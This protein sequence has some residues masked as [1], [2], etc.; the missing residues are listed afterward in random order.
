MPTSDDLEFK[1]IVLERKL[2]APEKLE[3][4]LQ[5]LENY[6]K[7]GIPK[8]LSGVLLD[9]EL[10]S[11]DQVSGI[12]K[13][14]NKGDRH[15]VR[16]YTILETLG[17]GGLGVVYKARRDNTGMFVALKIMYPNFAS[18]KEFVRRFMKEAKFSCQLN[19]VNVVKGIDFGD[20]NDVFYFAMEYVEGFTLKQYIKNLGRI[21]EPEAVKI[22]L[23]A[24]NGLKHIENQNL[25]H[26]DIKPDN[27]MLTQED[28]TVKLC[29]LGLA[30]CMEDA[31][32]LTAPGV[33]MGTPHYMSPEQGIAGGVI[34]I[35]SDIYSLGITL[36]HM[37]SGEV[38]YQGNTAVSILNQHVS[39]DL[40]SPKDINADLSES[41][42]SIISKMMAKKQEDRY[43]CC[44]DLI[45]DLNRY[46]NSQ[47]PLLVSQVRP[48]PTTS[49]R[50][51]EMDIT[52]QRTVAMSTTSL[53]P[54]E[55]EE[56]ST[57][58]EQATA[59]AVKKEKAS[60]EHWEEITNKKN[61]PRKKGG[62][63][64]VAAVVLIGV[65]AGTGYK[66]RDEIRNYVEY[67]VL[68]KKN[69]EENKEYVV[70]PRVKEEPLSE[71][72]L[73]A[74]KERLPKITPQELSHQQLKK[75]MVYIAGGNYK[76]SANGKPVTMGEFWIDRHEVSNGD[77]WKFCQE[78]QH[79]FP[80]HWQGNKPQ[81]MTLPVTNVTWYDA[82]LY[83]VW[84]GKRLPTEQ[85]WQ[86]VAGS[87][88]GHA[89]PWG[90]KFKTK[91]ANVDTGKVADIASLPK[92]KTQNG[93]FHMTGNV[94]EWTD[95][96]LS[97]A[98]L[99]RVIKGGSFLYSAH[100]GSSAYRDGFYPHSH[101]QDIGFRCAYSKKK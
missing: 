18:N 65:I 90:N 44:Q 25:I 69:G 75:H 60:A 38:P 8:P 63:L 77:Y 22:I 21:T 41:I 30:K 23:Q 61:K 31:L 28:Q 37:V 56:Q 94:W 71:K 66:F 49:E 35:R 33:V 83:S 34:D 16:G 50:N 72:L 58:H 40:P 39:A 53:K 97:D 19:H 51:E 4:C 91:Y 92:G 93:V 46:L 81:E 62:K 14:L 99:D 79:P 70:K 15:F 20:S 5:E 12:Y 98:K 2:V 87:L 1:N 55:D 36:F 74:Y 32:E 3:E 45:V 54:D 52:Q 88:Q 9:K 80:K 7:A 59:E 73:K 13:L 100:E 67:N 43:Q 29:D 17:Q 96:F 84:A 26:R 10:I 78:T 57:S 48:A 42:C 27:I 64:L 6:E 47:P 85:E 95:S 101:R 89:Y 86:C 11:Q 82:H 24:T 76:L 68:A